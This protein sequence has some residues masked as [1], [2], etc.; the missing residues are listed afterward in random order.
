M[1]EYALFGLGL[2]L[3]IVF[4]GL[5][6]RKMDQLQAKVR[7][8]TR[9]CDK[10]L[11]N[12]MASEQEEA[13]AYIHHLLGWE[14]GLLP[15]TRGWAASPDVLL[16]LVEYILQHKPKHVIEL[17]S[18]VSTLIISRALEQAGG[19]EL[20]SIDHDG[21]FHNITKARMAR[22]GLKAHYIHAPLTGKDPSKCWYDLNKLDTPIDLLF[23]DGPPE[24][25]HPQVRGH[26]SQLF[27][28][29]NEGATII[30]DDADRPG[31]KAVVESWLNQFPTL[32]H[33]PIH[34]EKG[35]AILTKGST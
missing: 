15:P 22:L 25:I 30:L 14:R 2:G 1:V 20:T 16:I 9:R 13:L 31:E 4:I 21:V 18:G 34:T 19:G 12:M 26:A 17:G 23:I 24:A 5:F 35:T 32:S 10:I 11:R 8:T 33:T 28:L 27:S 6:L 29:L 3:L 7:E